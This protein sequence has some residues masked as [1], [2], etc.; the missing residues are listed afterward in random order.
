VLFLA[1]FFDAGLLCSDMIYLLNGGNGDNT[2]AFQ[3]RMRCLHDGLCDSFCALSINK[4]LNTYSGDH[5]IFGIT[6]CVLAIN[7][8]SILLSKSGRAIAVIFLKLIIS[9]SEDKYFLNV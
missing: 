3:A 4:Y 8:S 5:A 2:I 9:A 7:A 6:V 1:G